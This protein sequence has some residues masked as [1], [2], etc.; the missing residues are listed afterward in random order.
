MVR[1]CRSRLF[2]LRFAVTTPIVEFSRSLVVFAC[3]NS[4][5]R[6]V[7]LDL[8]Y[9]SLGPKGVE[10]VA[11]ALDEHASLQ[12]INLAGNNMGREGAEALSKGVARNRVLRALD[13]SVNRL[14]AGAFFLFIYGE[15]ATAGSLVAL[16]CIE[17]SSTLTR[18]LV[19]PR[20]RLTPSSLQAG[21][22][23]V[24]LGALGPKQAVDTLDFGS[25]ELLEE[26]AKYVARAV[27]NLPALTSLVLD[28]NHFGSRGATELASALAVNDTLQ[29][30]GFARNEIG[31]DGAK[32]LAEA[33][34][35]NVALRHLDA[36]D[37]GVGKEGLD[38]IAKTL[39]SG[40]A[41]DRWLRYRTT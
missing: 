4:A 29:S 17:R 16:P 41:L 1:S 11:A 6:L 22:A 21:G 31:P 7:T 24:L 32:S 3:S 27:R 20:P 35:T 37:N 2:P 5:T 28:D 23:L 13:V 30:L 26:G 9:N 12:Y 38:H 8:S 36:S 34:K 15:C 10:T 25:N 14:Q 33:L 19:S 40:H 39:L 18:A